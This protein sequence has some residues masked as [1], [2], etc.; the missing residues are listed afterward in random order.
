MKLPISQALAVIFRQH[1][2][3]PPAKIRLQMETFCPAAANNVV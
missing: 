3:G 1:L 2:N